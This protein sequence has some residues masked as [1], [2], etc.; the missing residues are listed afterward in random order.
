MGECLP[1]GY[2][3]FFWG[4]EKILETHWELHGLNDLNDVFIYISPQQGKKGTNELQELSSLGCRVHC[5]FLTWETSPE[6]Y[7]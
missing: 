7:V 4:D 1:N 6:G 2:G 3:V 5:L